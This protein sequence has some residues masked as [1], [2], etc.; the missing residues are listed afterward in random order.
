LRYRCWNELNNKKVVT[1]SKFWNSEIKW[2]RRIWNFVSVGSDWLVCKGFFHLQF[3]GNSRTNERTN[4]WAEKS[5]K[6]R[7][8]SLFLLGAKFEEKQ[9]KLWINFLTEKENSSDASKCNKKYDILRIVY[10]MKTPKNTSWYLLL[11]LT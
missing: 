3:Y 9:K 11:M 2:I 5:E 8:D 4:E 1:A 10:W 7:L 6:S